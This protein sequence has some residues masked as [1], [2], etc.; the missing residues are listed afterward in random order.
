M[1]P[2]VRLSS[3]LTLVVLSIIEPISHSSAQT[4]E[5][6]HMILKKLCKTRVR[7]EL[8]A[9]HLIPPLRLQTSFLDAH[10][11]PILDAQGIVKMPSYQRRYIA[12]I[13]TVIPCIKTRLR[14]S[15]AILIRKEHQ[16]L[17]SLPRDANTND[18]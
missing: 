4:Y 14:V 13:S 16:Q 8:R 5:T 17:A 6:V 3:T 2:T 11:P 12:R 7:V 18:I 1:T 9:R 10:R 15:R